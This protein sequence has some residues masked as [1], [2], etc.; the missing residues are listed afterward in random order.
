VLEHAVS[1]RMLARSTP[2]WA[3]HR[4]PHG[5]PIPAADGQV[6]TLCQQFRCARTATQAPW[7]G[8]PTRTGDA[9]YFDSVGISSIPDYGCWPD[10]TS[11]DI[12]VR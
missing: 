11:Q 1:D 6:P 12:S 8:F 3:S 10:A 9:A 4:D 2:S 5:D 7:P